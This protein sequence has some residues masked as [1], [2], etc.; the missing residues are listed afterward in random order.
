MRATQPAG[1]QDR[2]HDSRRT[3]AVVVV[4]QG[5]VVTVDNMSGRR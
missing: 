1:V 2:G 4:H 3:S 5:T